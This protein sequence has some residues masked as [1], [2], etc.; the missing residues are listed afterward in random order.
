MEGTSFDTAEAICADW[1]K[2]FEDL[3]TP[4]QIDSFDYQ[5]QD[6]VSTDM[7]HI[8]EICS[9]KN[10]KIN[11]ASFEEVRNAIKRLKNNKAADSFGLTSE[12][13]INCKN[14]I[15]PYLVDL[16][17]TI[18]RIGKIPDTLKEGLLTPVY[19]QG[20]T[21]N[22]SNY[23]GISVTP[24][25]L[26]VVEHIL[27]TRQKTITGIYAICF[28]ERLHGKDIFYECCHGSE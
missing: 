25:L 15:I 3:S 10:Q 23:R 27:Y 28:T 11:P 14:E 13:I 4:K 20:D 17:N 19:K 22:P 12:H 1:Q 24:I 16:V 2:H 21:A 9:L 8:E 26:K 5:Y 6:R 7:I 18:L